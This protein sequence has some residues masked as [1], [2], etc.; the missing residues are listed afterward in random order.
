MAWFKIAKEGEFDP[1]E[2]EMGIKE[3]QEHIKTIEKLKADPSLTV[4]Q[5]AEMIATDHLKEDPQ[6]Y[7]KL[8]DA[9]K[10]KSPEKKE[11]KPP[12]EEKEKKEKEPK[13][14]EP[15]EEKGEKPMFPFKKS[16]FVSKER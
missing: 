14:K 9:M 11:E 6:Y 1:K 13:E 2:L 7:S 10:G 8:E 3:E 4:E 12:K 16:W 5:I 15:K